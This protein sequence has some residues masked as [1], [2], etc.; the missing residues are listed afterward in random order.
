MG[1]VYENRLGSFSFICRSVCAVFDKL[2]CDLLHALLQRS[3][4]I[5]PRLTMIYSFKL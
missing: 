3:F 2:Q 1:D 5:F 4:G